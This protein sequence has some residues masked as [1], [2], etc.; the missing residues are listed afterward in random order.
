QGNLTFERG[1]KYPVGVTAKADKEREMLILIQLYK[2]EG[3]NWIDIVLER[4]ALTTKPQTFLFEYTHNDDTMAEH[5]GWVATMYL[6]LKGTWWPMTGDTVPSKVWVDR[7]HVGEQPPLASS[8]NLYAYAPQ[9]PD[10]ATVDTV[11]ATLQWKPGDFAVSH[12]VY[13][14]HDAN[15]VAGGSVPPV[16]TTQL[17]HLVGTTPPYAT[18]LTPGLNYYWRVDEVNDANPDSPWQGHL[19][20]FLVRPLTAWKPVPAN[21]SKF[22]DPEQNLG[23]ESG[24]GVLFHVVYFGDNAG[25]VAG[26]TTGGWMTMDPWREPGTLQPN[27]TY[28]WRVD[29][30][31]G[32][33]THKG[34]VW[35]FTTA[36]PGGGLKAEYFGNRDLSGAPAVTRTDPKIDFNWGSGNTPGQHSPDAKVPVNDFSAR[37]TGE[38]TVDLTDTYVF[39]ITANDGFRLWLD[40]RPI[41]D[42]WDNA[43]T[44]TRLSEPI[45]LTAGQVCTLRMDYYEGADTALAQLLWQS[46]VQNRPNARAREIVPSGALGLPRKAHSPAPANGAVETAWSLDLTWAA[47]D[48]AAQHDVYL[49]TDAAA[50]THADPTTAG[51]YQKRLPLATTI[52]PVANLQWGVTYYWRV[53]ELNP[54]NPASPWKGSLWSFTPADFIVVDDFEG[55]TDGE[56]SRVYETWIDGWTNLTGSLVGYDKAPFAEQETVRGGRQSMP[57]GYKNVNSPWYSEA[58]RTWSTVQNWTDSGIDTLVLFVYGRLDNAPE[59]L[60]VSL[61]DST[62]KAA[63]VVHPNSKPLLSNEWTEWR[64]PLADFAGVNTARI[65]KMV[66]GV[67]DRANPKQGG[68]GLIYVD[69]I[70]AAKAKR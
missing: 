16:V 31:L 5:P 11:T 49:G 48:Q 13:F 56:G 30:F 62:S 14:G 60:Y 32:P 4:V 69:D 58:E 38:L 39:A 53:D 35:S 3:P 41:I 34:S 2:P 33:V 37:W 10:G 63:T 20:N 28:Y 50:V 27:K 12:K 7:V 17:R 19:W 59:K 9:P 43:A 45:P 65:K 68:T 25:Q 55:Y 21:G 47:G 42:F 29:E 46:A 15:A 40:G 66:I 36:G 67:G 26:A 22:V 61:Q 54:G 70:R 24:T 52:F 51:I 64:I 23:W 6:M 57:L 1:K 44:E 18:G 8:T